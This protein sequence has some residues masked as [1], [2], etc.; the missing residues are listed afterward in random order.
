M[1]LH[2]GCEWEIDLVLRF[3]LFKIHLELNFSQDSTFR[4]GV[5]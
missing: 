5:T 3:S 1:K 4:S 2:E